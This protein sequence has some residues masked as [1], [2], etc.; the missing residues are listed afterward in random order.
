MLTGLCTNQQGMFLLKS[1]EATVD[2]LIAVKTFDWESSTHF[3]KEHQITQELLIIGL[4]HFI[5]DT[6]DIWK[7]ILST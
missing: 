1:V 3:H 4:Y 5:T 7:A 2:S 6:D